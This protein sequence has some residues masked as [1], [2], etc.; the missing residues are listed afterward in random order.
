MNCSYNPK[1]SSIES[2]LNSLSKNIDSLSSKYDNFILLVDINS[3]IEDSP[4]KT[5]AEVYKLRNLTIEPTRK[6]P[7]NPACI[8]LIFK[9]NPFSFKNTYVIE[10]GL[11]DSSCDENESLRHELN[12]QGQ[13]LNEKGLGAFST[14]CAEIFDK[15]A[16]KRSDIYDITISFSLILKLLRQS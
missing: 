13:F 16:P 12:V 5:F 1:H 14:I 15:H 8:D 4:V 10:A 11:S 6:N 2:H 3:C 9:N 7:E